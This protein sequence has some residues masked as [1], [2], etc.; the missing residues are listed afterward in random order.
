MTTWNN[1]TK[2][3]MEVIYFTMEDGFHYLVGADED[4]ILVTQD[5]V[6]WTNQSK[7]NASWS[8][9]SKN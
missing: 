1:Q 7:N 4:L 9:Q 8:N 3:I 5:E 6:N 2:N